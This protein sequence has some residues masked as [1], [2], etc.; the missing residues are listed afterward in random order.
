[1][2]LP[3]LFFA[4][5]ALA[6]SQQVFDLSSTPN[7]QC[8]PDE[9]IILTIASNGTT[10]RLWQLE[11]FNGAPFEV[12]GDAK[13]IYVPGGSSA[14][15]APGKQQFTIHCFAA[16]TPRSVAD[17]VLSRATPDGTSLEQMLV[18]L[19]VVDGN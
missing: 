11:P 16:A 6:A 5:L 14:I 8:R 13:G 12:V 17:F 18:L 3:L 7:V 9:A 1:M 19:S 10:G 15:G 2:S 4:C